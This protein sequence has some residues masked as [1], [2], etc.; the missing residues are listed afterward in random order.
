MFQTHGSVLPFFQE[1]LKEIFKNPQESHYHQ[2]MSFYR[3]RA[4]AMAC[5]KH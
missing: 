2:D 1:K 4:E 3:S 5:L